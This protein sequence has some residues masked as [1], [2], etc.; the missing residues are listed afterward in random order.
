MYLQI[1]PLGPSYEC[2]TRP[3]LH[4]PA[5]GDDR[6]LTLFNFP[7]VARPAPRQRQ[8]HQA[9]NFGRLVLGWTENERSTRLDLGSEQNVGRFKD[10][11]QKQITN[12]LNVFLNH[13]AARRFIIFGGVTNQKLLPP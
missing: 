5:V 13:Q 9:I 2:L 12:R 8:N 11:A 3:P 6:V 10:D 4:G 7:K 1:D